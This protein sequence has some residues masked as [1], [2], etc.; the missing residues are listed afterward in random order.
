MRQLLRHFCS[1]GY[2][3]DLAGWADGC[4][5]T[6]A[7]VCQLPRLL[8][9]S[10]CSSGSSL[11]LADCAFS[12]ELS[13]AVL[14]QLPRLDYPSDP[15]VRLANPMDGCALSEAAVV[16]AASVERSC[17]ESYRFHVKQAVLHGKM[18]VV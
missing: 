3:F 8:C 5:Q 7:T 10:G 1:P 16:I 11:R 14:C 17:S 4:A 13:E 9:S 6:E 18:F 15:S 2:S 12:R